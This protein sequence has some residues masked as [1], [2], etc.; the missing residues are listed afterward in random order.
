MLKDLTENVIATV[1]AIALILLALTYYSSSL[2]HM[3]TST[4]DQVPH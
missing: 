1:V 3:I 2:V 4:F